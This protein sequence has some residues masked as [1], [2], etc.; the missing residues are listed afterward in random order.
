MATVLID[1]QECDLISVSDRGL[2]YGDGLFE[3]IAVEDGR[4][5]LWQLHC[6]RLRKGCDALRI[7]FTDYDSLKSEARQLAKNIAV[8]SVKIIISS[9][10]GPRGYRRPAPIK[11]M[12]IVSAENTAASH[13]KLYR[14]GIMAT[15]CQTR[16]SEQK[17]LAGVKHLNRLDQVLARREWDD[18]YQEGV[19]FDAA[20]YAR[21][22]TMSNLFIL[23]GTR[24]LTPSLQYCGV[25]GVMREWIVKRCIEIGIAV[26]YTDMTLEDLLQS[27]GLF[28]CNAIIRAWP[29]K[30]LADR[31]YDVDVIRAV[32]ERLS[33]GT[34]SH[35]ES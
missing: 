34:I 14:E 11:P 4:L 15:V 26:K 10:S 25:H 7:P 23:K 3:T 9:G 12:R 5:C 32:L 28:F 30:V 21:E 31:R 20:G 24:L 33:F 16:I 1:G 2:A 22:G 6:K 29:V 19:M 27:D 8:G 13:E 35:C 17:A 18:Q